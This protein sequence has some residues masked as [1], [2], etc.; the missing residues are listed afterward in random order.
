MRESGT[1]INQAQ[2]KVFH[3]L[4]TNLE[5]ENKYTEAQLKRNIIDTLQDFLYHKTERHPM[6][7][8]MLISTQV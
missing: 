5:N 4:K 3:T 2:K 1:L 8:P 6:I 7:L